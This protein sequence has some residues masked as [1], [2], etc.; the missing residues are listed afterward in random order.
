MRGPLLA[1]L[2]GS[3][4]SAERALDL[5]V[6][7]VPA[8]VRSLELRATIDGV[9]LGSREA[10]GPRLRALLPPQ[11]LYLDLWVGGRAADRCLVAAGALHLA[12]RGDSQEAVVALDR[13]DGA[14][15][16]TADLLG[17]GEGTLWLDGQRCAGSCTLRRPRGAAARLQSEAAPGSAFGG[18][19]G[20]CAG[21]GPCSLVL[22]DGPLRARANLIAAPV[23][24]TSLWCWDNPLPGRLTLLGGFARAADDALIVGE[25]GVMLAWN[26]RFLAAVPTAT[27][28]TLRGV[29]GDGQGG[30]YAVG[31]GGLLLRFDGLRWIPAPVG[32]QARLNAVFSPGLDRAFIAGD[33]GL[34]LDLRAGVAV[35]RLVPSVTAA[36][37]AVFGPDGDEVWVAGDNGIIARSRKA[38]DA[39]VGSRWVI[40][41]SGTSATLRALWGVGRRDLWAVGD[42]GTVLRWNGGR[43]DA[44]ESGVTVNLSAVGGDGRELWVGGEGGALLRF[45]DPGFQRVD[46]G[47]AEDV[48]ALF[49]A[50]PS[51]GSG[52]EGSGAWAVGSGGTVLRLRAGG[53]TRQS[54][55]VTDQRLYALWGRG[56]S[57]LWAAGEGGV[58]LHHDG[59]AWS[60]W[61]IPATGRLT[62]LWGSGAQ[63]LWVGGEALLHHD[64]RDWRRYPLPEGA[65]VEAGYASGPESFAVTS[66]GALWRLQRE[67]WVEIARSERGALLG[68]WGSSATDIWAVGEGGALLHFDGQ[69]TRA[70]ESTTRLP[71]A[72]VWGSGPNSAWA[73]G[74]LG[75]VLRYDGRSWRQILV[76]TTQNLRAVHGQAANDFWVVGE[77]GTLLRFGG[78]GFVTSDSGATATLFGV[79]AAGDDV[80]VAGDDGI[81]L[82]YRP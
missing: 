50:E 42:R 33:D 35:K 46:T 60:R 72:A 43:W 63:D 34:V 36:L 24:S 71:L 68:L 5:Q 10:V 8:E 9:S 19:L 81:L 47:S 78:G 61:P 4:C 20:D 75:T 37:R 32:T 22:G 48:Q 65:W 55:Q 29:S 51:G 56:A 23:C 2:L 73:V 54:A 77:G 13:V 7:R 67:Q 38:A 11:A 41:P 49:A 1:A 18:W 21:R 52:G 26:G 6:T 44:V 69:V 3:G 74:A 82:R 58:L 27:A 70:V 80:W 57:D 59:A 62:A 28:A 66:T 16:L 15:T 30:G 14:C 12:L 79:Y 31:D 76:G 53:V 39:E 25:R 40:T 45:R 17:E 64:G